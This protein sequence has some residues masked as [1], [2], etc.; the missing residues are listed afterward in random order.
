MGNLLLISG[1]TAVDSDNKI[2]GKGDIEAQTRAVLRNIAVIVEQ[3]GGSL[4]DLVA[5]TSY[6]TDRK[7]LAG[8]Y[9]TRREF[10][11]RLYPPVRPSWSRGWRAEG[12]W[13]R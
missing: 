7:F 2:I 11:P 13:S 8:F 4:H 5:T 1:Q 12:F 9:K 3:T 6:V 10:L